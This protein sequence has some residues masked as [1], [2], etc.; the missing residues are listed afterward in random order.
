MDLAKIAVAC[1]R[2]SKWPNLRATANT[3][4]I[5][6]DLVGIHPCDKFSSTIGTKA[7]GTAAEAATA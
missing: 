4:S 3:R 7:T 2:L 1:Q 6:S 5:P